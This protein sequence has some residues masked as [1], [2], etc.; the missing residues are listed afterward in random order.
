MPV[1]YIGIGSNMGGRKANCRKAVKLLIREGM[2]ALKQSSMHET[3]PD[4]VKEQPLFMNMAVAAETDIP[5]HRL[6]KVLKS[7]EKELGRKETI[8]RGPRVIDLDI[9][10]YGDLILDEPDLKIPHPSMHKRGFV[11][12]PLSEIAPDAVHPVLGK[13]VKELFEKLDYV[14]MG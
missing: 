5:P 9:L 13:T 4:G 11:L 14:K 10:L 1:V 12:K 8:R 2:R 3:K 6:L 7:I